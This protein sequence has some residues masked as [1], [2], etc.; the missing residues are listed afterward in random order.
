MKESLFCLLFKMFK[1][2]TYRVIVS[3]SQVKSCLAS[4]ICIYT[5]FFFN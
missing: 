5:Y 2:V 4:G 1:A 3:T